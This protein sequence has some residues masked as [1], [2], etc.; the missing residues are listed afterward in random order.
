MH[1]I[2]INQLLAFCGEHPRFPHP[3]FDCGYVD[4]VIVERAFGNQNGEKVQFDVILN[5]QSRGIAL[6]FEVKGGISNEEAQ[7]RF[8]DQLRRYR[9]V[10]ADD[11]ARGSGISLPNDGDVQF[12]IVYCC[13]QEVL[14]KLL[15]HI[16][17][18][19]SEVVV[20]FELKELGSEYEYALVSCKVARNGFEDSRLDAALDIECEAPV[21]IPD[22]FFPF[23]ENTHRLEIVFEIMPYI[24][25]LYA[26]TSR[27]SFKH[28]EIAERAIRVWHRLSREYRESIGSVVRD[29]VLAIARAPGDPKFHWDNDERSWRFEESAEERGDRS[30]PMLSKRAREYLANQWDVAQIDAFFDD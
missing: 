9:D 13:P 23:D 24:R 28:K 1:R 25:T 18:E 7:V 3:F 27:E 10:V 30:P 29:V 4:D 6:L 11:V 5:S 26:D 19:D 2:L 22:H 8:K 16:D 14:G 17:E 12:D 20:C 21:P 15:D